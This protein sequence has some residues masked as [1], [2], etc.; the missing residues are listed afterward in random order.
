MT[1]GGLVLLLLVRLVERPL[2]GPNRPGH[3][4]HHPI[5]LP[6]GASRSCGLR[7]RAVRA[8]RCARTRR[9]GGQPFVLA[10]HLRAERRAAGLF[11][12]Q[13]RGGGLGRH[14]LAGAGHRHRLHRPQGHRGQ[15]AAGAVRGRGCARGTGCCSFPK[16][17]APT[18]MRV[19]PFKSTLFAAFYTHGLDQILHI[20]PVTVVYHAPE[21]EDPRYLRLVGRHGLC[22]PPAAGAGG[23]AAGPGRGDLSP[24]GAGGRLRRP[25]GAGRVLRTGGPHSHPLA[26]A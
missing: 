8:H 20:Q 14:R 12:G 23:T 10:G 15:G 21:G 11:R 7:L 1:Y 4:L 5:R 9:G 19:L 25:Q 26:P 13:V 24:P 16:A 22:R 6:R 2:F 17:P 3:A 18:R